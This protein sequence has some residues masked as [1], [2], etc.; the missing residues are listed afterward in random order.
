MKEL[1]QNKINEY[2]HEIEINDAIEDTDELKIEKENLEKA[3][4]LL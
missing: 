4:E 3:I 1:T 2:M